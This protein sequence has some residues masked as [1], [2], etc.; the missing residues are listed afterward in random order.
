MFP[1]VRQV[2]HEAFETPVPKAGEVLVRNRYTLIS[3]GTE[4]R[5]FTRNFDAGMYWDDW[6]KYPF[7]PGY[8]AIGEVVALGDSVSGI[9]LGQ[10]VAFRGFHASHGAVAAA[11][12]VPVPD[13]LD[14]K[15]AAWFALAKIAFMGARASDYRAGDSVLIIGAGPIGQMS[16]RWAAAAG[17]EHIVVVEPVE[18]RLKLAL[19][20]GATAIINKPV[21]QC[22]DDVLAATGGKLPRIVNDATGNAGVFDAAL[23]LAADFGRVVMLGITGSPSR[24]RLSKDV[25]I[26][27]LTIIGAHDA[28]NDAEWNNVTVPRLFFSLAS[29]GRFDL[30]GLNT[31]IF[32]PQDAA[33]AYETATTRLGE[34]MG[35]LFDW[36][37]E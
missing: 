34:T 26:R 7:C 36:T 32:R 3:T 25:I 13:G 2:I 22:R 18:S 30:A 19:P 33:V 15:D 11:N 6:I 10:R 37:K 21:D 29:R 12:V 28:H 20:G 35:I 27:G 16:V 31:H 1:G 9:S 4:N 23:G 8:S 5:V 14:D 17:L 24:Q